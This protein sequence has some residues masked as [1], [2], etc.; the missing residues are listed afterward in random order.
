[1]PYSTR[2]LEYTRDK[3]FLVDVIRSNLSHSDYVQKTVDWSYEQNP[4]CNANGYVLEFI[5]ERGCANSAGVLSIAYRDF[6][7]GTKKLR[8]ALCGDFV[9][10][11]EH[12]TLQPALNLL[13]NASRIELDSSPFIYGF[14]NEKALGVLKMAGFKVVGKMTRYACVLE[15]GGYIQAKTGNRLISNIIGMFIDL[16]KKSYI[17]FKDVL[18]TQNINIVELKQFDS[19]LDGMLRD[20]SLNLL[21][22]N[23]RS[24]SYLNWRYFSKPGNNYLGLMCSSADN[25]RVLGY[26]ILEFD[27]VTRVLHVRDLFANDEESIRKVLS[28]VRIYSLR[29][30]AISISMS[31]LAGHALVNQICKSGFS[32]RESSRHVLV[33]TKNPA[34]L[35]ILLDVDNWY[36][37][38]GDEDQ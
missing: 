9:V 20:S 12:R 29:C 8:A 30:N 16:Y 4:I 38:D 27:Q 36:V 15:T 21:T 11:N 5:D 1:M 10:T 23:C 35:K 14:P 19:T 13:K 2:Q 22:H 32:A 7:V 25:M 37:T 6:Y 24:A 26:G 18:I 17:Y 31:M 33:N 3:S 34:L 28:A